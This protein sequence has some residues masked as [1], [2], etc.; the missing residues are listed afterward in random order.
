MMELKTFEAVIQAVASHVNASGHQDIRASDDP[1]A[2]LAGYCCHD[3]NPGAPWSWWMAPVMTIHD[4]PKA[5]RVQALDTRDR[6]R[7][8][9]E[10]VKKALEPK[11]YRPT[12]WERVLK[13]S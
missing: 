4:L 11:P 9:V 5:L 13:V 1:R 7:L 3:C 2:G 8:A 10:I 12:A 6:M